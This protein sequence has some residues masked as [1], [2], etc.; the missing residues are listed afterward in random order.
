MVI[1]RLIRLGQIKPTAYILLSMIINLKWIKDNSS[2]M[3]L[4]NG[5]NS[6]EISRGFKNIV[7]RVY[8]LG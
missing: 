3:N 6:L 5:R 7:L 8:R 2:K 4:I 1:F